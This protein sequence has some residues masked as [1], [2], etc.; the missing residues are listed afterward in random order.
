[1]M[2]QGGS[3]VASLGAESTTIE[4]S[5]SKGWETGAKIRA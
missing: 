2:A 1:M 5:S 4:A 3:L